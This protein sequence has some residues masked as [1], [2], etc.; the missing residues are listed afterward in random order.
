MKR[1]FLIALIL[2]LSIA[3]VACGEKEMT[4]EDYKEV[5]KQSY[6]PGLDYKKVK[7]G[8]MIDV[9]DEFM[10]VQVGEENI[11][12]IKIETLW[13]VEDA[14]EIGNGKGRIVVATVSI[15]DGYQAES[16]DFGFWVSEQ[17]NYVETIMV[18]KNGE[19]SSASLVADEF[20]KPL[21]EYVLEHKKK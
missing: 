13:K 16:S 9:I 20:A 17:G 10:L 19:L 8:E 2:M 4:E 5:V 3:L 12:K 15:D 7:F 1:I 18:R 6:Y 11:D 14:P 21:Q